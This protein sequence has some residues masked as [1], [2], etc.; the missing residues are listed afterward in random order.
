[1]PNYMLTVH[2]VE[3]A[4]VPNEEEIQKLYADVDVVNQEMIS[5]GVF[6]FGGG[7][8]PAD[9]ATVVDNRSGTPITTDGPFCETKEQLGGFWIIKVANLDEALAWA[10]K[11]SKACQEILEVR[12]F[13]PEPEDA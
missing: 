10:V 7:L 5:T 1:M 2:S 6:V 12:P 13:Q 9:T 3:G 11:A 4:P 8:E